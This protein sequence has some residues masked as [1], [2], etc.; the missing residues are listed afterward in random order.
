MNNE[1]TLR[2]RLTTASGALPVLGGR[3]RVRGTSDN[4][5]DI[6]YTLLTQSSGE[7]EKIPLPAPLASLSFD[8]TKA[9]SSFYEYSV[10]AAADGYEV[11]RLFRVEVFEGIDATQV[12]ELI[13]LSQAERSAE[14][15]R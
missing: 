9:A 3:I 4:N 6:D 10:E 1:G 14:S 2:I 5:R 13:P 11:K 7:T 15:G 8:P 12:M